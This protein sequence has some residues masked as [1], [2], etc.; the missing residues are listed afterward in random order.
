MNPHD[1]TPLLESIA[2]AWMYSTCAVGV[3]LC[4]LAYL[5]DWDGDL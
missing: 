5:Q 2:A 3:L 4:L 1:L